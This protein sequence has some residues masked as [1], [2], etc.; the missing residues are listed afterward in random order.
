MPIR[1]DEM[2]KN[3]VEM[4]LKRGGKITVH[5]REKEG[6]AAVTKSAKGEVLELYPHHF[7]C[8]VGNIRCCFRY[9]ELLGEGRVVRL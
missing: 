7:L 2:R 6:S 1:T 9:N 3:A 8:R 4:G 5:H